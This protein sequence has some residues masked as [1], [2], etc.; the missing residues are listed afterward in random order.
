MATNPLNYVNYDYLDLKQGLIDRL[1]INGAWLDTYESSTGT[2]IIE[3]YAYVA[4]LLL[5][6]AERRAEEGYIKTAQN[7]SSILNLVNLINYTPRR[8]VS[9]TGS[10]Q[11]TLGEDTTK[12]VYIPKYTECE[13]ADGTKYVTARDSSIVPPNLSVVVEGLQG[14]KVEAEYTSDGS[15]DQT[16]AIND[17]A[18]ENTEYSVFVNGTE[19]TEVTTFLSSEPASQHYRVEHLLDDNLELSFGNGVRGLIP[20]NGQAIVF[21]YVRSDGLVGNVYQIDLIQQLNSV[22]FDE[23][24]AEIDVTVTN[25]TSFTA[26]DDEE[27]KEY[28]REQAP[29]VFQTGDRAVTKLDFKTILRNYP[30]VADAN[31]WGEAEEN[32]P[33]YDMFNRAKLVVILENWEHPTDSFKQTLGDYLHALSMLT[34]KYEFVQAV[35]L[36]IIPTLD[37]LVNPGYSLSATAAEIEVALATQFALGSTSRLGTSINYSNIVN[38]I[39]SLDSV[40][41]HHLVLQIAKTLESGGGYD[42]STTLEGAPHIKRG[43][44]VVYAQT[45]GRT[46][47]VMAVDDEA[48]NFTDASSSYTVT[49][50][51]NY[52]T[53]AVGIDFDPDT[54]I[55]GVYIRYQQNSLGD[56]DITANEIC[57]LNDVDI[58]EIGYAS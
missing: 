55:S 33:N 15:A 46:D 6:Y 25:S 56:I 45:G 3:F 31:A 2:M 49:G 17:T 52:D 13:T 58:T 8:K 12:I 47:H 32:A 54:N 39:D 22:I 9:A 23:D 7:R 53:G 35:V 44:A 1:K 50:D 41:H 40:N 5:H 14:Q 57:Q 27:D 21:R 30:S 28:I 4:N 51:I 20:T 43:T 36:Q 37:V 38:L 16:F 24:S 10:L 18:V 26:G 42:W 11:F 34:V 19:W 48:G 29:Q